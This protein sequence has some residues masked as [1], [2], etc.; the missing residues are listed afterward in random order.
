MRSS[1]GS[2]VWRWKLAIPAIPALGFLLLLFLIP[3]SPRWLASRRRFDEA[4]RS[5]A[6]LGVTDPAGRLEEWKVSAPSSGDGAQRGIVWAPPPKAHTF[7]DW[8]RSLQST[9]W[10]QRDPLLPARHFRCRRI[11]LPVIQSPVGRHRRDEL[12][13]YDAGVNPHRPSRPQTPAV[14]WLDWHGVGTGWRFTHHEA[15]FG[16]WP[17][18]AVAR[19]IHRL[20]CDITGRGN[21]GVPKRNL[22]DRGTGAGAK[23]R[24]HDALGYPML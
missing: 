9:V 17:A 23:S 19:S 22:S 15:R 12:A 10:Y 6:A 18:A 5:L 2:A 4:K 20:V 24:K 1:E 14:D 16:S 13:R 21:L 8:S 7:G 11:Q 3:Q